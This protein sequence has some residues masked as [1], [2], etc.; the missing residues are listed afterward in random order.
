MIAIKRP[1]SK[2]GRFQDNSL[3]AVYSAPWI[4]FMKR[5]MI[6]NALAPEEDIGIMAFGKINQDRLTWAMG[7]FNGQGRNR[8]AVVSDKEFFNPHRLFPVP[9]FRFPPMAQ[10]S[11]LG[12][13]LQHRQQRTGPVVRRVHKTGIHAYF[14]FSERCD[15]GRRLTRWG[16]EM[17]YLYGTFNLKA[18][19]IEGH[20]AT[21]ESI[22]QS[23]DLDLNGFYLN[24]GYILTGEDAPRDLP[25]TPR[26]VFDPAQGGW[27]AWQVVD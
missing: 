17:E 7:F 25:I 3:E 9:P 16:L 18:E 20:F 12:G 6:V 26:I 23:L 21:I 8:D 15:A 1:K 4:D 13:I 14:H 2:P 22:D 19:Y 11:L 10:R 27:G 24:L 5:A